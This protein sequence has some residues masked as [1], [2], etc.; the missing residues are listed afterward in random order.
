MQTREMT[1]AGA[2]PSGPIDAAAVRDGARGVVS[3]DREMGGW[4]A[5]GAGRGGG[6]CLV[7]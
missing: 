1:G 7:F 5:G 2:V 6:A 4:S 3:V